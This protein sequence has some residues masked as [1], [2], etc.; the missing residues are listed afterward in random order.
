M[1]P[2]LRY[3]RKHKIFLSN[4]VKLCEKWFYD[5]VFIVK[6]PFSCYG[7]VRNIPRYYKII[8]LRNYILAYIIW[9]N[10]DVSYITPPL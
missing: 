5:F 9:Y 4:Y 1:F 6:L 8:I 10:E 7:Q 3:N 2:K